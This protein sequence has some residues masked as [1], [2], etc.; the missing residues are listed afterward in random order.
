MNKV[1]SL[2]FSSVR[3]P[4]LQI[5][6]EMFRTNVESLVWIRHVGVTLH[7]YGNRKECKHLELTLVF[8]VTRYL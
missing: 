1:T 2:S 3:H 7:Q 4:K 5:F 6:A 8:L